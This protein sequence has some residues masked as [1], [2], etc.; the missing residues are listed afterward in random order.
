MKPIHNISRSY[1]QV[2]DKDAQGRLIIRLE[3]CGN[4]GSCR[5]RY[6]NFDVACGGQQRVTDPMPLPR[7]LFYIAPGTNNYLTDSLTGVPLR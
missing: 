5:M 3:P 1:L 6:L 7:C 2:G 4:A